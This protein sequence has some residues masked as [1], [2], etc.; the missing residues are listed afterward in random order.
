VIHCDRREYFG[1]NR[2]E[3]SMPLF[4]DQHPGGVPPE[5]VPAITQKVK[6]GEADPQFGAKAVNVFWTDSETFCLSEAPNAEAV[7]KAHE[8]IGI[9]LAGGDV[10]QI[11][12]IV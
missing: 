7:H 10:R 3:K 1:T 6:S 9:T 8:A 4:L 5:M 11:K 2:K 12:S